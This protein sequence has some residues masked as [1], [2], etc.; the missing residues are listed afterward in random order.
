MT[1]TSRRGD[2]LARPLIRD[3]EGAS[4]ET[5]DN[6]IVLHDQEAAKTIIAVNA[7]L[8]RAVRLLNE[9]VDQA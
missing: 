4:A 9:L 6:D 7:D 2:V 8:D 3:A 5:D 1:A